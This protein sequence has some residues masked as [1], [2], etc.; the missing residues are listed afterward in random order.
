MFDL[1][2]VQ[3]RILDAA[4]IL[5]RESVPLLDALGR[6]LAQEIR[7]TEDHP[8]AD[9]SAVD[10]YAVCHTH[11]NGASPGH[12]T[13]F[14]II[15]EAPAGTCC[16]AVVGPGEAVRIM[17]GSLVPKGADTV[18]KLEDASESNGKVALFKNRSWKRHPGQGENL[19]KGELI[20]KAGVRVTPQVV[21]TLASL[22]RAYVYVHRRPV[23]AILSTGSELSGFHH[24]TEPGRTMCSN[25]YALAAHTIEAGG[26][27]RFTGIVKD[28]MAELDTHLQEALL[29]DVVI[30]SGGTSKGRYDLVHEAFNDLGFCPV[31]SNRR[32][33]P[34]KPTVCGTIGQRLVFALPGNPTAAMIGF[35]QFIR[36]AL[37]KMAGHSRDKI[38]NP[39]S[40]L[41]LIDSFDQRHGGN[42]DHC[43][44]PQIP[45][46]KTCRRALGH[47]HRPVS[48]LGTG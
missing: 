9:L 34:G 15:A 35:D 33:K 48:A 12:P 26:Q 40:S 27:P 41:S 29:A 38:L 23:V 30:T 2:Q 42:P 36:P 17:T 46:A 31:F 14:T 32:E 44:A 7:A 24:P 1:K 19:K 11:L 13:L 43:R 20:F 4:P 28:E 3:T 39:E 25:I 18:I 45:L 6:V 16:T 22:R 37:M 21:G 8:L 10:G 5:G 47:R